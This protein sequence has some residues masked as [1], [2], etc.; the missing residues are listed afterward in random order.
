MRVRRYEV[1]D[2]AWAEDLIARR[3]GGRRQA[4]RGEVIDMLSL[5]GFVAEDDAQVRAGILCYQRHGDECELAG[6][7]AE[8][9]QGGVGTAL[10]EA[11]KAEARDCWRIWVVTTND[12]LD[13]LRFYQRRGFVLAALRPGAVDA[14]RRD[15]KPGISAIGDYGIPLR[16]E[17]E[18]E[19]RLTR[20]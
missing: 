19:L 17:I 5:D 1:S 14:A 15:L 8:S 11:L 16:D 2:E 20:G 4:R 10:V 7:V 13:A 9:G 3:L 12:N 18:L 6:L